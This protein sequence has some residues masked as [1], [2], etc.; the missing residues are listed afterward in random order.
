MG[1]TSQHISDHLWAC[2][3]A[4]LET[5]VYN[6]CVHSGRKEET[7]FGAM[8]KLAVRSQNTLVNVVRFLDMAQEPDETGGHSQ[9]D[10]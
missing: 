4:G 1:T 6:T 10:L 5:A 7:L 2:Y 3:E 9:Q 8:K